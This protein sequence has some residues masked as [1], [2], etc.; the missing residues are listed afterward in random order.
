M[1]AQIPI[2][3]AAS[4]EYLRVAVS[5]KEAGVVVNPTTDAVA[6]AVKTSGTPSGGDWKTAAWETDAT[7]DPDTYYARVLVGT[8]TDVGALTAGDTYSVWVRVS[9]SPEVPIKHAGYIQVI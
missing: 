2:I 9:D 1:P 8:G 7:T 5:A 4:V 6:M 3:A